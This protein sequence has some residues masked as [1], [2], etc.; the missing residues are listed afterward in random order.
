MME[1]VF[2]TSILRR[3]YEDSAR[4][5]RRWGSPIGPKYIQCVTIA[6]A[7]EKFADLYKFGSLNLHPLTGDHKGKYAMTIH[8]RWRLIVTWDE[9]QEI[10]ILEEVTN[11][12]GD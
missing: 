3:C 7:A 5:S 4:A 9:T 10:L 8:G 11:H 2:R 6:R 1:V 12:Y